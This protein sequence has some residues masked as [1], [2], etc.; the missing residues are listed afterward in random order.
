MVNVAEPRLSEAETGVTV[1]TL[2]AVAVAIAIGDDQEM[3][4][5]VGTPDRRSEDTRSEPSLSVG[6]LTTA[7]EKLASSLGVAVDGVMVTPGASAT[8]AT[9]TA[10]VAEEVAVEPPCVS[11]ATAVT[12]RTMSPSSFVGGVRLIPAAK[13]AVVRVH[14]PFDGVS[15]VAPARSVVPAGAPLTSTCK[16]SDPSVSVSDGLIVRAIAVSSLPLAD[17]TVSAGVSA[18]SLIV[19]AI[20]AEVDAVAAVPP[21][22]SVAVAVTESTK[23]SPRLAPGTSLRP[24]SSSRVSV[25]TPPVPEVPA[26]RLA[27]A[28]TPETRIDKLSDP[29]SSMSDESSVS[30]TVPSSLPVALETTDRL[31]ASAAGVTAIVRK[32]VV[33]LEPA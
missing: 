18:M 22:F 14:T 6:V 26:D 17:D 24:A 5:P 20:V 3:D 7:T 1:M 12:V 4:A 16:V 27:P 33:L 8:A 32:P 25:Q 10:R 9:V 15:E 2:P 31:G 13:C 30:D 11:V 28:V 19:T 23:S 29:S 21:P